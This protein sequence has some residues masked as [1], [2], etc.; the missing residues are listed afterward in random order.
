MNLTIGKKLWLSFG[1][2]LMI[3]LLIGGIVVF[4]VSKTARINNV[5]MEVSNP[6]VDACQDLIIANER[7]SKGIMGYLINM[8]DEFL[9][10]YEQG[11]KEG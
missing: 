9:M 4:L 10:E 7:M 6:T 8:D 3:I 5:V 11:E 1:G 2:L